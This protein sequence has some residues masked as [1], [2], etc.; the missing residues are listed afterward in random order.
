M[1]EFRTK[2]ITLAGIATMFAGMAHAQ[3]N[4]AP[5]TAAAGAVFVASEGTNE[6]VADTV[7]N[8]PAQGNAAATVVNLSVYLSPAVSITSATLGSGGGAR[9][10]TLAGITGSIPAGGAAGPAAGA[11]VQ[12]GVVSGSS[13]T[14]NNITIPANAVV[15]FTITNIKINASQIA[16]SGGA[17]TAVTETIFIG[18]TNVTPGVLPA[19]NVAFATNGL[20]GVKATQASG[21]SIASVPICTGI[22]AFG[23]NGGGL[24]TDAGINGAANN[25]VGN[26][27]FNV[28]FSEGFATAFKT[29]G[30]AAGNAALGSEFANNTYTGFGVTAPAANTA[31]SGTRVQIVFNNIPAG[32]GAIYVP[33]QLGS[34]AGVGGLVLTNSATGA[35][36]APAGA[37]NNGS[38][39]AT[40]S[41][42]GGNGSAAALTIANGSAT[43]IYEYAP[44][45]VPLPT[46]TGTQE[47]YVVPVMMT[48]GGAAVAAPSGALTATVSFAPIGASSNVPNFVSGSST[49][50]VN[51]PTF[52]AC[53]TTLLFPFVTN[54]LG[55]DT[56]V[57]IANASSDLSMA[58][59][60]ARQ[61]PS[62][63][64]ARSP[65]LATLHR[66]RR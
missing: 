17:P 10:E 33:L 8:C 54:Q 51:G 46:G 32:V 25:L 37:T 43:A 49:A 5:C 29:G 13:I 42:N 57:A 62:L 50:T 11:P 38:P 18:G 4:L 1:A 19:V 26:A 48:V 52:S 31:S 53:S 64:L 9:S 44:L 45:T 36:S 34:T 15:Q 60:R 27:A 2:L 20:S 56:G 55:F 61:R 59:R 7:I 35:L 16:N 3:L 23:T 28:Q 66:P 6:Q 47:T 30:T 41:N 63:A 12:A 39:G 58:G 24:S 21:N 65:S 22:N 14:F 40:A